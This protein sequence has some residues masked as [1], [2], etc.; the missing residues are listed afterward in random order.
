M[1][2]GLVG[3]FEYCIDLCCGVKSIA[4]FVATFQTLESREEMVK[5]QAVS[6]NIGETLVEVC[7]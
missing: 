7:G 2:F 1:G 3:I 4:E 6:V 5:V